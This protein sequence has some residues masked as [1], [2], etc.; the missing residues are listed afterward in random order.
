MRQ[1]DT[2][3]WRP[4]VDAALASFAVDEAYAIRIARMGWVIIRARE[5]TALA[6]GSGVDPVGKLP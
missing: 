3:R 4:E 6:R 1:V 5:R 2:E